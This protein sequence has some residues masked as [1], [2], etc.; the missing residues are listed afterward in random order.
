MIYVL[1]NSNDTVCKCYRNEREAV[2]E[3]TFSEIDGLCL[4]EVDDDFTYKTIVGYRDAVLDEEIV[5]EIVSLMKNLA[6]S[7]IKY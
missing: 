7:Q 5:K 4:V 1:V 2:R 3:F 6:I